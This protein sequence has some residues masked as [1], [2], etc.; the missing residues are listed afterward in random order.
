MG[1]PK[2]LRKERAKRKKYKKVCDAIG[3]HIVESFLRDMQSPGLTRRF[4]EL[5][6]NGENNNENTRI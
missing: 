4:M 5:M 6:Q 2:R 1:K 3:K